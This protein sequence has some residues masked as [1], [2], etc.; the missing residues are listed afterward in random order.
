M[1]LGSSLQAFGWSLLHDQQFFTWHKEVL[2]VGYPIV[3]LMAV[4]SLGYCLGTWYTADY[5]VSKRQ[6]NLLIVGC[7]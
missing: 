3:P 1:C 2:L 6:R 7:S 4:M 5:D